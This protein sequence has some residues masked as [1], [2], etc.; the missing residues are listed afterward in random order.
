MTITLTEINKDPM[1]LKT[2][3]VITRYPDPA[4]PDRLGEAGE[5]RVTWGASSHGD[6]I[7]IDYTPPDG[8]EGT[9]ALTG[10]RTV[11]VR[12]SR[13]EHQRA[14]AAVLRELLD[15]DLP[16]VWVWQLDSHQVLHGQLPMRGDRHAML[17]AWGNVLGVGLRYQDYP[18]TVG[19]QWRID[20]THG[21]IRIHIWYHAD[22]PDTPTQPAVPG[23]STAVAEG[24][25]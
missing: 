3:D 13:A 1:K 12:A 15:L 5:W 20:G 2:G 24:T 22:T 14:A 18:Q 9:F 16:E 7:H 25:P 21:G 23:P 11:T 10:V 8:A 19:G 17:T 6:V 4:H